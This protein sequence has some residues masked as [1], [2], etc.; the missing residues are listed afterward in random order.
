MKLI[1]YIFA[2]EISKSIQNI[3]FSENEVLANFIT[4]GFDLNNINLKVNQ[5]SEMK[6]KFAL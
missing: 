6:V 2:F 1:E 4:Q 5:M 3:P